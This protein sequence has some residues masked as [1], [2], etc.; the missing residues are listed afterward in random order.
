MED[1]QII[2]VEPVNHHKS[3]PSILML[4]KHLAEHLGAFPPQH[5]NRLGA[6]VLRFILGLI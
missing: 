2:R 1:N 5:A 3:V 6:G 4:I